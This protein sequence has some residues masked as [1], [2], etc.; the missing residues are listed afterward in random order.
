MRKY[1]ES[2]N[3]GVF[4]KAII[5]LK[6]EISETGFEKTILAFV[7]EF[8]PLS[9]YNKIITSE[10]YLRR[11]TSGKPNKEIILEEIILLYMENSNPAASNLRE[12]YADDNL[13]L[14]TNYKQL[15][16]K[17]EKFFD[18]EIPTRLGG[19]PLFKLLRKPISSNPFDL[20][21]QLD[22]VRT[23]WGAYLGDD[24]LNRLLRELILSGKITNYSC[25]T[26]AAKR[27]SS[28]TNL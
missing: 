16:E 22:F 21:K 7:E 24:L 3:P 2:D 9:V 19:L 8:P 26:E 14:K 12:L 28:R 11:N 13:S 20:E 5:H 6:N 4:G 15:I 23:E 10:E 27:N 25:L 17:T 18:N 1:E